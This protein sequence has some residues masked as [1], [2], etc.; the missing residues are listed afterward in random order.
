M[1]VSLTQLDMT[2]TEPMEGGSALELLTFRCGGQAYAIDIMSV[3]EIRGWSDP[4][5]MP[6]SPSYM[7]GMVNLRGTVLPVMDLAIRL[8]CAPTKDNSRNVII[9]VQTSRGEHG[10][11]V[12][13]VSDIVQPTIDEMQELPKLQDD[14]S[15]FGEALFFV[16]N[17]MVQILSLDRVI[18]IESVKASVTQ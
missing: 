12:E 14:A 7:I 9:I 4:T 18:P 10:L 3:K 2:K 5:R 1:T 11:L 13:A 17:E 16:G 15:C 8:G 6:H